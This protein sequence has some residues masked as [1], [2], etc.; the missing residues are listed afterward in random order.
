MLSVYNNMIFVSE[1]DNEGINEKHVN[2]GTTLIEYQGPSPPE[3][4]GIHNYTVLIYKQDKLYGPE[5]ISSID[6]N[7]R[8]Y[9][10]LLNKLNLNS[11][12]K[13]ISKTFFTSKHTEKGGKKN[14]NKPQILLRKEKINFK[15]R[16]SNKK[17]MKSKLKNVT[18]KNKNKK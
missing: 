8:N 2:N 11:N 1:Y 13:L 5:F 3:N 9:N 10:Y 15:Q 16:K 6:K 4:S 18:I 12:N 14:I 17:Q 7:N